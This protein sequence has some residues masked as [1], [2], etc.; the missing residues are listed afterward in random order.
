M[1]PAVG[2]WGRS[3]AGPPTVRVGA[4]AAS[5]PD[6]ELLTIERTYCG[7]PD[8]AHGGVAVG[9]FAQLVDAPS[10]EVRLLAPP[11]VAVLPRARRREEA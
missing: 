5:R 10:V 8:S 4:M 6:A 2:A 1:S 3:T 11:P 9:R 7:P